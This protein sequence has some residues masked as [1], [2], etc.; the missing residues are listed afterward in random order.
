MPPDAGSSAGIRNEES[1]WITASPMGAV[2]QNPLRMLRNDQG[3]QVV[4]SI[5]KAAGVTDDEFEA[6]AALVSADLARLKSLVEG[7]RQLV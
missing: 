1:R 5:F 4:F 7:I 6:D 2:V 3:S